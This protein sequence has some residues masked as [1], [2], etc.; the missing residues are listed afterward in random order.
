MRFEVEV[1][2]LNSGAKPLWVLTICAVTSHVHRGAASSL[3]TSLTQLTTINRVATTHRRRLFRSF[4]SLHELR[5]FSIP[6]MSASMLRCVAQASKPSAR[7]SL[8]TLQSSRSVAPAVTCKAISQQRAA[9]THAISNPT[10]ANIEKRWEAMPP[11]EQ[12]NLW[13]ALRDRMKSNWHELTIQERKAG[14]FAADQM[15]SE[16][17]V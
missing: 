12:A 10:L 13:M 2:K 7:I 11:Q 8:S 3:S 4:S 16:A 1:K 15:S 17:F 6:T 14:K 9:S 5:I